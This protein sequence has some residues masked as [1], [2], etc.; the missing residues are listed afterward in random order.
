MYLTIKEKTVFLMDAGYIPTE[1]VTVPLQ[2]VEF[3]ELKYKINNKP[4]AVSKDGFIKIPKEIFDNDTLYITLVVDG[5]L[6]S[7]D[8][9]SIRNAILLGDDYS[10]AYPATIQEL[11]NNI[12]TLNQAMLKIQLRVSELE[13]YREDQETKGDL[14]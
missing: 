13:K 10:T 1:D 2:N 6:Y 12:T 7:S 5:V 11:K 4:I 3:K 14:I 9:I 8:K